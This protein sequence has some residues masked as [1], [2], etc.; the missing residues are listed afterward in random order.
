VQLALGAGVRLFQLR[1]KAPETRALYDTAGALCAQVHQ[2]GGLFIVNDRC[3]V[4]ATVGADGIHLGQEDLP[5]ADARSVLGA[6]KLIGISTH[7]LAQAMEA[8]AGGADYIGFGPIFP[9]TTKSNPDPVVGLSGLREARAKV[10][11]PIVAIGGINARNAG[12]AVA[13]GA[14]CVAVVS[15]VLAAPDPAR[16]LAE[17]M[18]AVKR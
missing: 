13:A 8:A 5:L 10:R 1:M 18:K 4:A 9:T 7:N 17:L 2:G 16:A 11:L 3:D 15:A 12:E 14:D 6:G